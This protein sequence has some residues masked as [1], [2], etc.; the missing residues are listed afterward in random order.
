MAL[1]FGNDGTTTELGTTDQ[2]IAVREVCLRPLGEEDMLDPRAWYCSYLICEAM[3]EGVQGRSLC[4][5]RWVGKTLRSL[6]SREL[7]FAL[8]LQ[9]D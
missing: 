7:G 8:L 4:G 5:S 9:L 1:D 3:Q 6:K 2:T